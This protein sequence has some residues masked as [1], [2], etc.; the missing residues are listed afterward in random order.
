MTDLIAETRAP[1]R[2]RS[3]NVGLTTMAALA[4]GAALSGCSNAPAEPPQPSVAEGGKPVEVYENIFDCVK[5]SGKDEAECRDAYE[6]AQEASK[7]EA[8][9]FAAVED[10]EQEWG[11]GGCVEQTDEE[12]REHYAPFSRGFV[13]I[14]WS[15]G[16]T[17]SY[18]PLY[19]RPGE[20]GFRAANGMR[21]GYGGAPGK[22]VAS[23]RAFEKPKSVPKV[24]AA[25]ALASRG[26]FGER[27]R[28]GFTL[29]KGGSTRSS[30]GG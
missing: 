11:M 25:S 14:A 20:S 15:S 26:G 3:R 30:W 4:G 22:Y 28:S 21:L 7:E 24:K 8:P 29:A 23:S 17:P 10:C 18:R 13:F 1:R 19:G 12:G 9:R 5:K 16:S 2:R 27:S 6:Q